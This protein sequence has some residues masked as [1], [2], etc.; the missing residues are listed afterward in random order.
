[1]KNK[2]FID[3]V[4]AYKEDKVSTLINLI[5]KTT[6]HKY[7]QELVFA[8]IDNFKDK[9]IIPALINLINRKI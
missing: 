5:N 3:T 2:K 9:R 7:R 4:I 6:D 1:M 8:L